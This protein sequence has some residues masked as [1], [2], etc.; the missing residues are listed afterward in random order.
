MSK[1]KLSVSS[2][3]TYDKCPKNYQYRYI[4]KPDVEQVKH[5]ATE[6]GSCAH[7]ALELFHKTINSKGVPRSKYTKLMKWCYKKALAEFDFEI[8]NQDVWTPNGDKNGI[9]YL[10]EV[11][12]DYLN[13]ISKDGLPNVIGIEVPYN[14]YVGDT[15]VRG[16]IDRLDKISDGEYR[17]VDYKTSKNKKYLKSFQLRVYAEAIKRIYPDAK[18]IHGSFML[19]KHKCETMDWTFTDNDLKK[20]VKKISKSADMI[21]NETRWVKKPSILCNWCDY[22]QI[23]QDSW[24]D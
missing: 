23:C 7:L 3:G 22:K 11:L 6:F 15:M 20:T 5:S 18:I 21:N 24:A 4:I 8:L 10:K 13:L 17:V 16:Y 14:F 2:I 12:Q 19:L 9:E 1:L